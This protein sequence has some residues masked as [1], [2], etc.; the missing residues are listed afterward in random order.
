MMNYIFISTH[1]FLVPDKSFNFLNSTCFDFF[2]CFGFLTKSLDDSLFDTKSLFLQLFWH[3]LAFSHTIAPEDKYKS[4]LGFN[5]IETR[6][7]LLKE[8]IKWQ[9]TE[10]YVNSSKYKKNKQKG[11]FLDDIF[12]WIQLVY[13]LH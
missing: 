9:R 8:K 4:F 6:N 2:C 5:S 1:L 13:I 10:S 3:T 7:S 12:A 11:V